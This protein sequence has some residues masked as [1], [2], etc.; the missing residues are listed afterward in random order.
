MHM[1][2][3]MHTVRG[4]IAVAVLVG[5]LAA[6]VPT[7]AAPATTATPEGGVRAQYTGHWVLVNLAEQ[8][9]YA[10]N[11]ARIVDSAYVS[12]GLPGKETPV[13][14]FW[15]QQRYRSTTMAG[16][17]YYLEGVP[18]TQYIG[19]DWLSWQAGYALHGTYWHN[20]FGT[21]MSSGCVNM[22]NDFAAFIWDFAGIGTPVEVVAG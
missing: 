22:R 11:G 16:P 8:R 13:G 17:G 7:G 12:T 19:N 18:F 6:S 1:V 9:I 20:N 21:P 2:R 5:S 15:V 14:S 3:R 10:Y 4:M